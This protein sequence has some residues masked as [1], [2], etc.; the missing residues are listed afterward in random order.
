M[1]FKYEEVLDLWVGAANFL[2]REIKIRLYCRDDADRNALA[3]KALNDL[4]L[5]WDSLKNAIAS[6]LY[7]EY[8]SAIDNHLSREEFISRIILTTVDFDTIDIMYTLFFSESGLFGGHCVQVLWDP[9][10][11]FSVNVS[12]AG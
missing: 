2:G 7:P 9:E 12:L 5:H 3:M 4:Q 1:D 11:E 10:N 8:C 6:Q